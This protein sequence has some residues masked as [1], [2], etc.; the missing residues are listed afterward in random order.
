M[1]TNVHEPVFTN[2]CRNPR[3]HNNGIHSAALSTMMTE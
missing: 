3:P 1:M 2:K